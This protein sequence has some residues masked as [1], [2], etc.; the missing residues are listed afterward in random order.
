MS[1]VILEQSPKAKINWVNTLF[2]LGLP[3]LTATAL[4]FYIFHNG[5]AWSDVLILLVMYWTTGLAITAG[6]HRYYSHRAFEC[7][8]I[9]QLYFLLFGAA[10]YENSVECWGSDHRLHHRY[11]DQE[12]DPYNINK[13]FFWAHMGWIFFDS[14]TPA[15][16]ANIPDLKKD[17]LVQWQHRHYFTIGTIVGFGVPLAWGFAFGRPLGALLWGGF[18]R[19]IL[20]HHGTFFINSAAHVFGRRPYSIKTSA[21]DSDWLAFF[22]FGEGY[23][24]FHHTFPSDYRNGIRWYQWD[25]TKWLIGTLHGFGFTKSLKRTDERIIEHARLN[26]RLGHGV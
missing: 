15:M 9:V 18:L 5:V 13:G 12:K 17:S 26:S 11:V 3:P 6:Y 2:L 7:H 20:V 16:P 1:S 14:P 19:V 24:N 22:S 21:R 25:P 10:A 4:G 23:H 8:P